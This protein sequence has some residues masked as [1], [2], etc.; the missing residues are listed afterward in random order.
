M[1]QLTIDI[2]DMQ[3]SAAPD[4]CLVTYALGSCIAVM[5]HDPVR[6]AGGMIHYMLPQAST[7]PE[8][9]KTKPYMFAD[10]GIPLLFHAM[11]DLGCDKRNLVVKVAG[12]AALLSMADVFEI[13]KRNHLILRKMLWKA[14]V[15]IKAEDVGGTTFR[16]ARLFNES[17]RVTI[18]T[19]TSEHEL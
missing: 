9:A 3:V 2:A 6:R 18:K 11:Y 8:K 16:T 14:G 19:E 7:A 12:G 4:A 10:T 1:K 5:V 15:P 17:G 13:G